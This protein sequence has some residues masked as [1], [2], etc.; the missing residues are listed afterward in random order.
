MWPSDNSGTGDVTGK[1]RGKFS[2]GLARKGNKQ[3][4]HDS[5][6]HPFAAHT[7]T[8]YSQLGLCERREGPA[9]AAG[10][11]ECQAPVGRGWGR[12]VG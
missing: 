12:G 6:G 7:T 3:H 1:L 9:Q 4:E 5:T 11:V 8:P 10:P 2:T